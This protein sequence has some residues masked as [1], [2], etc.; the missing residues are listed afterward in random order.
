MIRTKKNA[1]LLDFSFQ[2]GQYNYQLVNQNTEYLPWDIITW[3]SC[4]NLLLFIAS[5][6]MTWYSQAWVI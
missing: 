1:G 5:G 2:Q 6:I 4:P 3:P